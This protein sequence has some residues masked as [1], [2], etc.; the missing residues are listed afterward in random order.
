MLRHLVSQLAMVLDSKASC[1]RQ[2]MSTPTAAD[3]SGKVSLQGVCPARR[4]V[5][6][7]DIEERSTRPSDR[8]KS[9]EGLRKKHLQKGGESNSGLLAN[10]RKVPI[11]DALLRAAMPL[12][13]GIQH[14][15]GGAVHRIKSG[16]L[17]SE[18]SRGYWRTIPTSSRVLCD[19]RFPNDRSSRFTSMIVFAANSGVMR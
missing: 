11:P 8:K 12:S 2:T 4:A 3:G 9:G 10:W 19:A 7:A 6:F 14:V 5:G 13:S 1:A 16:Q 15:R 18:G 17:E